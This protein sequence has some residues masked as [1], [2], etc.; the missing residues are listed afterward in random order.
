[1]E[2]IQING[3]WYVKETSTTITTNTSGKPT[4]P[5]EVFL[6]LSEEIVHTRS[7]TYED[8][9]IFLEC[10]YSISDEPSE[11]DTPFIQFLDKEEYGLDYNCQEFW[12]NTT[13]MWGVYDNNKESITQIP[14]KYL[15]RVRSFIKYMIDN[16]ILKKS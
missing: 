5:Q 4:T 14:Y 15:Q 3:E 7:V 16:N 8:N 10:M 9:E 13:W 6:D 1:M 2:R 12:D 11:Y